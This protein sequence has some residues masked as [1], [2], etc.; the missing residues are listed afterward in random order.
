LAETTCLDLTKT[1]KIFGFKNRSKSK[2]KLFKDDVCIRFY[3]F[4]QYIHHILYIY[5]YNICRHTERW[6]W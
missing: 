4:L 2:V 5:G 3:L 1:Q 6:V